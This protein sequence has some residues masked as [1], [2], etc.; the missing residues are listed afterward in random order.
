MLGILLTSNVHLLIHIMIINTNSSVLHLHYFSEDTRS[1]HLYWFQV[2]YYYITPVT[3]CDITCLEYIQDI[4]HHQSAFS[5]KLL[6]T[7]MISRSTLQNSL[8]V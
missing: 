6:C 1:I 4:L 3:S 8:T 5:V 7:Q 2:G